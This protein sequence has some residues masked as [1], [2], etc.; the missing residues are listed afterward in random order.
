MLMNTLSASASGGG[1][2]DYIKNVD[3]TEVVTVVVAGVG[4]V[5]AVL[6]VLILVFNIFGKLV[7]GM[8]KRAKARSAK[9]VRNHESNPVSAVPA[10]PA[11]RPPESRIGAA[12]APP[13]EM[14]VAP[15]TVAAVTAAIT[16]FEGSDRFVIR[17][18]K[19]KD[20]GGRNPWARAAIN[21]NTKSF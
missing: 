2:A 9:N 12:P 4:I 14:G 20:V 10:A 16:A 6:I 3:W 17:S 1:F 19:R 7:S 11:K 13:V 21:E 18:V 5:L 8:E 15:E